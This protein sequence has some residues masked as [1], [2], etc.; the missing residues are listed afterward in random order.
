MLE[1]IMENEVS[2][3]S[4]FHNISNTL[5]FK[6]LGPKTTLLGPRKDYGVN[7]DPTKSNFWF[8]KKWPWSAA[9]DTNL[10]MIGLVLH[11]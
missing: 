5:H 9:I 2:K 7:M 6:G 3:Y 10:I 11:L 8:F 4:I 1:N